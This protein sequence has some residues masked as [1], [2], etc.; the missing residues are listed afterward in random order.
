[1]L[2]LLF[3]YANFTFLLMLFLFYANVIFLCMCYSL[4]MLTLILLIIVCF[5]TLPVELTL[6]IVSVSIIITTSWRSWTSAAYTFSFK[7]YFDWFPASCLISEYWKCYN[8]SAIMTLC[9]M[10]FYLSAA[11]SSWI[12]CKWETYQCNPLQQITSYSLYKS[13][14][15]NKKVHKGTIYCK[16]IVVECI[17]FYRSFLL[18]LSTADPR[19][20]IEKLIYIVVCLK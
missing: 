19:E 15:M 9:H 11:C 6:F 18:Y 14:Q 7:E 3:R 17:T 5:G 1:M 13:P 8:N 2:T 16:D 4:G 10:F 12:V 20:S